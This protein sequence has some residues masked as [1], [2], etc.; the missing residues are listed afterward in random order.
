MEA[1]VWG[2]TVL[3]SEPPDVLSGQREASVRKDVH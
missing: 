1:S 2:Y 3:T